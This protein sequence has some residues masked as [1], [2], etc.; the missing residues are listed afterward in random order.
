[1]AADDRSES[2]SEAAERI[3]QM[4]VTAE[5]V[6][7]DIRREANE[8]AAR[9]LAE[10]RREADALVEARR[11]HLELV[12]ETLRS[13]A[14]EIERRLGAVSAALER[15]LAEPVVAEPGGEPPA[16]GPEPVEQAA[17]EQ[18]KPAPAPLPVEVEAQGGDG[19]SV[20][21][22]S[23]ARQR[24]LIRATQLAVQGVERDE[25]QRTLEREFELDDTAA[26]IEEILGSD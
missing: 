23:Q 6:S 14:R 24:A 7:E 18:P 8:E 12:L 1:M 9:Y 17:P 2:L 15:A 16:K 4:L 22:D 10:C 25:V 20:G 5:D 11:A 19:T 21:A 3:R 13:E 26:I